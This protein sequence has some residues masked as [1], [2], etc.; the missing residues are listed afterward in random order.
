MP[1]VKGGAIETLLQYLINYN[2][3]N[4]DFEYEVYSIYN[5]DAETLEFGG[6][7]GWDVDACPYE[8]DV[9]AD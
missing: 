4:N 6:Q 5:P 9:A 1:A 7:E 8:T 2:E 3:V